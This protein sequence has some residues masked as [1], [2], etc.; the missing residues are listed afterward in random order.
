MVELARSVQQVR[1]HE[2]PESDPARK[3]KVSIIVCEKVLVD[4]PETR[5]TNKMGR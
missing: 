2:P 5:L 1:T 4:G 3:A